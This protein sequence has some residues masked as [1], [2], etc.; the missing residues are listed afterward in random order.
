MATA[1]LLTRAGTMER[2]TSKFRNYYS[3]TKS[4]TN[5]LILMTTSTG[6][7]LASQGHFRIAGLFIH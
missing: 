1:S 4:E 6:Y 3:L 7:Y 5:L 2:F